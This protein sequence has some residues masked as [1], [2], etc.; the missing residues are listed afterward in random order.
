[1]LVRKSGLPSVEISRSCFLCHKNTEVH[2][3]LY[4]RGGQTCSMYEPHI[5]K[6]SY[7]EPQHKN[8]K[9]RIYLQST[10]L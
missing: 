7:K 9:T 1:L 10:L 6:T 4:N 5:V 8:L 3:M 2:D